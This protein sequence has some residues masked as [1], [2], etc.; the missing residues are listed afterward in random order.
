M[1]DYFSRKELEGYLC[2]DHTVSPGISQEEAIKAGNRTIPVPGGKKFETAWFMCGHCFPTRVVVRNP[3]RERE[4]GFCPKCDRLV[5][6]DCE[7]TRVLSG[8][9]CADRKKKADEFLEKALKGE[10]TNGT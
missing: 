5:C 4:R 6:D 2:I 8:G 1:P 7:L 3:D 10:M 9:E